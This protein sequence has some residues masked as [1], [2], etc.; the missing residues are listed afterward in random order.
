MKFKQFIKEKREVIDGFEY[1]FNPSAQQALALTK[2]W[3]VGRWVE[4]PN[5]GELILFDSYKDTHS[6]SAEIVWGI[7]RHDRSFEQYPQGFTVYKNHKSFFVWINTP[8]SKQI[9]YSKFDKSLGNREFMREP[10]SD[11]VY[12]PRTG[13]QQKRL[14]FQP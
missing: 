14:V 3:Q 12:E 8:P 5:T 6:H 2:K 4:N 13:M 9:Y 1:F 7:E 10:E 11:L